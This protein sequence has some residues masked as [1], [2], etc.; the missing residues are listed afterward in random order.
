M[1]P[2]AISELIEA[3]RQLTAAVDFLAIPERER[4]VKIREAAIV[5]GREEMYHVHKKE[6]WAMDQGLSDLRSVKAF[7][8]SDVND[9]KKACPE[10]FNVARNCG[11]KSISRIMEWAKGL[12]DG[13]VYIEVD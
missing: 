9:P 13:C 10:H 2:Q 11:P 1:K 7:A 12:P 8:R 6:R 5:K 3:I 4:G